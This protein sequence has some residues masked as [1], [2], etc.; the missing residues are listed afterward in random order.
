MT[1]SPATAEYAALPSE[2]GELRVQPAVSVPVGETKMSAACALESHAR[3]VMEPARKDSLMQE[4]FAKDPAAFPGTSKLIS[5]S[6]WERFRI[7][8]TGAMTE[9]AETRVLGK[10]GPR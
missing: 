1:V 7:V 8:L 3:N 4:P 6:H 2:H 10:A 9:S 5:L